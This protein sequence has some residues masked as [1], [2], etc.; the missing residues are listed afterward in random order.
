MKLLIKDAFTE[1]VGEF[2][3]LPW[4]VRKDIL[5]EY[6]EM[7]TTQ[8]LRCLYKD[9]LDEI[10]DPDEWKNIFRDLSSQD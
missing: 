7:S 4:E 3:K 8:S 2:M 5:S 1:F 6:P 10:V 9:L